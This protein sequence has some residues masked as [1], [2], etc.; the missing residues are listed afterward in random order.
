MHSPRDE[1]GLGVD[2]VYTYQGISKI[3][4]LQ[5]NTNASTITGELIRA[6]IEMAL[7]W[8]GASFSEITRST[9]ASSRTVGLN[10]YDN[11]HMKIK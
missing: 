2:D 11:L 4:I 10:P 1:G 3:A 7:E 5:E 6:S 8:N 9:N